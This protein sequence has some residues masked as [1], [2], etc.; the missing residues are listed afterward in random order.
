MSR[1]EAGC[2]DIKCDIALRATCRDGCTYWVARKF[3]QGHTCSLDTY[4]SHFCKVSAIV[5]GEMFAP[6]LNTNGRIIRPIDIITEMRE[7]HGVQLLYTTAWRVKEHAKNV[8]YGKPKDSYQLLPVYFHLLK[9]TNSD[10]LMAI[11]TD[12]NNNFLYAFFSLGQCIMGF[13]TVIRLVITIDAIYLKGAFEG[14]T[15][16]ASCKDGDKLAYPI[17]FGVGDDEAESSWIW[18]L[19]HLRE[20]IGEVEGMLLVSDHHASIGKAMSIVYP[21]VPHCI[22]FFHLKQNLK[23]RLKGRKEVLDIYYRAAYCSTSR[24]FDLKMDEIKIFH[25]G[26]YDY[27]M[28]IGPERWSR[29][30]CPRRRYQM[31]TTNIAEVLNNCIQKTRRLPITAAMEFLRDM[32]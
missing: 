31:M 20:A 28:S 23:T 21:N 16:V 2:N 10:T 11:H 30:H 29:S 3:T 22:C 15:Y 7:Q 32:L 5:I 8:L 18:F 12:K 14:V 24:E 4:E 17:A 9:V 6:K 1:F 26:T 19:E 27:L 13:Q 25:P